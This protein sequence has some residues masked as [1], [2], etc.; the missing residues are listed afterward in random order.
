MRAARRDCG[1]EALEPE[2][3][4]LL[5]SSLERQLEELKGKEKKVTLQVKWNLLYKVSGC[6]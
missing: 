6:E 3:M 4:K 5:A 2:E 1:S